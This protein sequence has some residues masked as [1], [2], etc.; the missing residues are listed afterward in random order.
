MINKVVLVVAKMVMSK[1]D[2]NI[3]ENGDSRR[4]YDGMIKLPVYPL[5]ATI[6]I[7][8]LYLVLEMVSHE[9]DPHL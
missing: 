7:L 8:N 1:L 5:N 3:L 4:S 6:C 9:G 2:R